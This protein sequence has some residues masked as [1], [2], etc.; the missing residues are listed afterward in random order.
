MANEIELIRFY[1]WKLNGFV[2]NYDYYLLNSL[3]RS[4]GNGRGL[5]SGDGMCDVLGVRQPEPNPGLR[6]PDGFTDLHCCAVRKE[7]QRKKVD[8]FNVGSYVIEWDG[9]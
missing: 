8:P 3:T 1:R 7:S 4:L 2:C 6:G 5:S 9:N